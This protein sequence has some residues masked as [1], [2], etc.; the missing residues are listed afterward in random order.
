MSIIGLQRSNNYT[1]ADLAQGRGFAVLDEVQDQD[2]N[3]F[4]FVLASGTIAQFDAVAITSAG[5]AQAV[6]SALL[7]AGAVAG[8]VQAAL[9]SGE[10]GW[11]QVFGVTS[12]NVL[13]TCSSGVAL[14]TS[15]TAGKLDDTSTSQVKV[16]GV[17]ILANITAA[18]TAGAVLTT[19]PFAAL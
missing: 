12:L 8:V 5:V 19:R 4:K 1:A 15:G 9:S 16:A 14:F 11:A 2:G 17:Q 6:T 10:Y 7:N 18:G 3:V 13:S